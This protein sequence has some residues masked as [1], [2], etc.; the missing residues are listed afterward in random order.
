MHDVELYRETAEELGKRQDP[1]QTTP[2]GAAGTP[3]WA[4]WWR[5]PWPMW[6]AGQ[7]GVA[8]GQLDA[9]QGCTAYQPWWAARARVMWL[10]GDERAAH[11]SAAT[12]AGDT[13]VRAFLLIGGAFRERAPSA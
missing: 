6:K 1:G 12:A 5:G 10:L 8:L 2:I 11:V 13:A 9:M 4:Q 7:G 3:K